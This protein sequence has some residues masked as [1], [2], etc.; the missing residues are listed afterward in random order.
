MEMSKIKLSKS[1]AALLCI[2]VGSMGVKGQDMLIGQPSDSL[3]AMQEESI[4]ESPNLYGEFSSITGAELMINYSG[5]ITK[6]LNGKLSGLIVTESSGEPG[7]SM[8]SLSIRGYGNYYTRQVKVFVDGFET[9]LSYLESLSPSEIERITVLK[10]ATALAAFGMKG[11]NG[12]LW[13]TTSRGESGD[14]K[15]D[16]SLRTGTQQVSGIYKPLNSYNY[17]NLYNEAISNDNGMIWTPRYSASEL[18]AYQDGT[19]TDVDWYDEVLRSPGTFTNG[20]LS[21]SGG[22]KNAQYFAMFGYLNNKGIYDVPTNDETSNALQSK[23]NLRLNIDFKMLKIFEGKVDVGG[24]VDDRQSPNISA[25]AL[26][27]NMSR[28]PSNIY[29]VQNEG[30]SWTGTSIYPNNPVASINALGYH[31]THDRNMQGRFA[32]KEDLGGITEGLYLE[33]AVYFNNWTRGTYNRTRNYARYIGTEIQTPD[34]NTNYAIFDDNGTNQWNSKHFKTGIAYL[35]SFNEHTVNASVNYLL[36]SFNVDANQNGAAGAQ[37]NYNYKNIGGNLNYNFSGKYLAE[38]A[39][40]YSGSDNYAEG[41]RW[42]FYPSVALHWKLSEESFFAQNNNINMLRLSFSAGKSGNDEY[43]NGPRYL[44]MEYY[45]VPGQ[46]TTGLNSLINR[47]GRSLLYTANPDIFAETSIKYNVGLDATIFKNLSFS[48]AEFIDKRSGI[49]TPDNSLSAL[50]GLDAPYLNVGEFTTVG[51]EANLHYSDKIGTLGYH[52][53]GMLLYVNNTINYMAEIPPP[54]DD[55]AATGR[56]VGT[57]FGLIYDGFYDVDDFNPDGTLVNSIPV[58]LYGKIQ[59]GDI[60]YKNVNEDG[61]IDEG[62]MVE[63]G[64]PYFPKTVYSFSMG[65]DLKGFDLQFMFQGAAGRTVNLLDIPTQSIAFANNGNAF[66]IAEER[67]AYYPDQG[68][69]TRVSANYPRLSTQSNANNYQNSTFWQKNGDYLKLRQLEIGYTLP[70]ALVGKAK[71]SSVRINVSIL[72]PLSFSWLEK[73]YG[74][75]PANMAG[76]PSMK[77][78]IA[79]ININL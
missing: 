66:P 35:R 37:N 2:L 73:N 53:S 26:W 76:Y 49:V 39:F 10:D 27:N 15:I 44:Y 56:S 46:F 63:I 55:A 71:L 50:Y 67:W 32:L 60:K 33:Q 52:F 13:V 57:S 64:A 38:F 8:A 77:S 29:P 48:I 1:F 69:D 61:F 70:S 4:K 30:G 21:F 54:S 7:S 16:F 47:N 59:P 19:G 23:Y 28:Y 45:T 9:E 58:P 74:I 40:A 75:D 42:G 18:Q 22:D 68:I 65:M 78:L 14:T 5:S 72:N 24:S 36:Q 43:F 79:G 6:S 12:V 41:N 31:S 3:S 51:T 11:S 20:N 34:L 25:G 17:T 62:D